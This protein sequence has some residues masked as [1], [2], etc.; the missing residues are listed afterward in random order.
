MTPEHSSLSR[1]RKRSCRH[2]MLLGLH[3]SHISPVAPKPATS[4][5]FTSVHLS[6]VYR[7][8]CSS[9]GQR[10]LEAQLEGPGHVAVVGAEEGK[11]LG[12]GGAREKHRTRYQKGSCWSASSLR[13][14]PRTH[15]AC[16]PS[17]ALRPPTLTFSFI[18]QLSLEFAQ[19]EQTLMVLPLTTDLLQVLDTRAPAQAVR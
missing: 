9:L 12:G 10:V 2:R 16:A 8:S 11:L 18:H 6:R 17:S 15:T 13:C 19:E 7:C 4:N 5:A 14:R 1:E 3:I